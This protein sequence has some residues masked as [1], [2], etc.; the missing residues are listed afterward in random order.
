MGDI[1]KGQLRANDRSP[2][3][4]LESDTVISRMKANDKKR[5]F[6]DFRPCNSYPFEDFLLS[7][8]GRENLGGRES[9]EREAQWKANLRGLRTP[10]NVANCFCLPFF[11]PLCEIL[12][13][14]SV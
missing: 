5:P 13:A 10:K 8:A 9:I 11:V 2:L 12:A 1:Y 3:W 6:N 4:K 14:S 7:I